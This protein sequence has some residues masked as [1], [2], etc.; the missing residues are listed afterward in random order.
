[1][2]IVKNG[3]PG[4]EVYHADCERCRKKHG[5]IVTVDCSALSASGKPLVW[6]E[7]RHVQQAAK[8][9]NY[10]RAIKQLQQAFALRDAWLKESWHANDRL[11]A[12]TDELCEEIV[13]L[14]AEKMQRQE[15]HVWDWF[16]IA[17]FGVLSL[18]GFCTILAHLWTLLATLP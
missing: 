9:R 3:C 15:R 5:E 7:Q 4:H 13:A 17:M 11:R 14:R 6:Y 18:I 16:N 10:R 12:R 8:I 1:M 2:T